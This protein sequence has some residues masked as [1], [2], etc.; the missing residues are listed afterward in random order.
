MLSLPRKS[1]VMTDSTSA[2]L[3][4]DDKQEIKQR[5]TNDIASSL[6]LILDLSLI[7]MIN[8]RTLRQLTKTIPDA[9]WHSGPCG[10]FCVPCCINSEKIVIKTVMELET[11]LS[12]IARKPVTGGSDQV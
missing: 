2:V 9:I 12:H 8:V 4:V 10:Q 3:S 5:Q 11:L 6:F 1:V 7:R